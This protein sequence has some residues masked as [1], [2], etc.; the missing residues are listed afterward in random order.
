MKPYL[1]LCGVLAQF[2]AVAQTSVEPSRCLEFNEIATRGVLSN[3]LDQAESAISAAMSQGKD[4][5]AGVVS[6]NVAVL[7]FVHGRIRDSEAWA[8][9]S[10]KLLRNKLDPYDPMLLRP[11]Y[12]LASASVK[13][14]KFREAEQAFDGMLQVRVEHPEQR[15]QVHIIGGALRQMQGMLKEAESEYLLAYDDWER[16]GKA[17]DADKAALLTYLGV[18]Y[19]SEARLQ[20]ASQVLDHALAIL[21]DSAAVLPY[22]RIEVLNARAVAHAKQGEWP[23]A[24]EK[25]SL[26]LATAELAGVSESAV[27]RP[28]LSRYAIA[29]RRTH[30]KGEARAIERRLSALPRNPKGDAVIDVHELSAAVGPRQH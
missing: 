7:L 21:A 9:R 27:L 10:L 13:Q 4:I 23:Q 15:A 11:L 16:L 24:R 8:A 18:L 22:D 26:A 20:E 1:L 28:I 3:R 30:R 5:C 2:H 14:G 19:L 29:L 25:L 17:A 6:G 12:A